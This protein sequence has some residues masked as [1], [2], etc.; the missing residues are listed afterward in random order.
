MRVVLPLLSFLILLG[1]CCESKKKKKAPPPTS[2]MTP[3]IKVFDPKMNSG[4]TMDITYRIEPAGEDFEVTVKVVSVSSGLEVRRLVDA[5]TRTGGTEYII[6]WDGKND[7]GKFV[8]TG[9]YKVVIEAVHQTLPTWSAEETIYVVRLGIV[10]LHFKDNGTENEYQLMFHIRNTTKYTYYAIPD[11]EPEWAIGK[12]GGDVA[13]LD[14]NNGLA[15]PLP[16]VWNGLN[17]PPQDASDPAG[18]EDD[19]YNLPVCYKRGTVPKFEVTLGSS[20]ASNITPNT[21]LGCGYPITGLPIRIVIDG[22][23]PETAGSNED[24]SPGGK[25]T[26]IATQ[27]LPNEIKKNTLNYTIRFEYQDGGTWHKIPG[28]ITTEHTV[29]TIYDKP[30]LTESADPTPPYLAWVRCVDMVC[31]W[32]NGYANLEQLCSIIT[33]KVNTYFGLQY[34]TSSGACHYTTT[35]T[36]PRQSMKMS[37]FIEDYDT[38]NFTVV[39]CSDCACLV[40]TFAN[41]IGVDHKYLILGYTTGSIPLNYQKPIGRN[42]M[43]PF[44]GYFNYHAVATKD[45]GTTI[46]DACCVLDNDDDPRSPPHTALLPVNIPYDTYNGLLSWDPSNYG[47][48]GIYRSGQQ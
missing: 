35:A 26:F 34:D 22:A 21:S 32:V 45:D 42:W 18:V 28:S 8:D 47:T 44:R 25:V 17:S 15:R 31:G 11:D 41:H 6:Q 7:S 2:T 14:L 24:I 43:I 39:N 16:V 46:S 13:D 33:D 12:E 1:L 29:Y 10:G 5:Q 4:L 20:A 3:Q 30:R 38:S 27:A 23:A 40:S 9:E 19:N 36:F 37:D 48:A